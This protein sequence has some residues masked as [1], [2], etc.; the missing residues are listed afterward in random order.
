MSC[1]RLHSSLA[2]RG[3]RP[4]PI[5]GSRSWAFCGIMFSAPTNETFPWELPGRLILALSS[6]WAAL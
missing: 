1:H 4:C 6:K 2:G 3:F 5:T